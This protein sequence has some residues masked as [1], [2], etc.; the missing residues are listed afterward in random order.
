M[1]LEVDL[2]NLAP[3]YGPLVVLCTCLFNCIKHGGHIAVLILVW[4][5]SLNGCLIQES[6][7]LQEF[8]GRQHCILQVSEMQH[9]FSTFLPS[10]THAHVPHRHIISVIYL[11]R[12]SMLLF[13][14]LFS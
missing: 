7:G 10:I 5:S 11:T 8:C 12:W 1:L 6:T 13:L 14:L 9:F 3:F 4:V 2:F